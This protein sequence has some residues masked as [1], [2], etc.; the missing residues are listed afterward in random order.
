MGF[1]VEIGV[2]WYGGLEELGLD[3]EGSARHDYNMDLILPHRERG[4][5]V[6]RAVEGE[7]AVIRRA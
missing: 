1:I 7:G 3:D 5:I 2:D 6:I 4:S